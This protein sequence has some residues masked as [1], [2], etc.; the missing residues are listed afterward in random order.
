MPDPSM[1]APGESDAGGKSARREPIDDAEFLERIA[2][3]QARAAERAAAAQPPDFAI[4]E[5]EGEDLEEETIGE[6]LEEGAVD[7]SD[8]A[9]EED[10]A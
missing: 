6:D 7:E 5:S 9:A 2:A 8:D 1:R 10:D 3:L 4:E